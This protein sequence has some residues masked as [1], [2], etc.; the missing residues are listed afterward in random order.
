MKPSARPN[1]LQA[2]SHIK[3]TNPLVTARPQAMGHLP[4]SQT[5]QTQNKT[6]RPLWE[7]ACKRLGIHQN[8]PPH[9]TPKPKTKPTTPVGACLQAIRHSAR[10]YRLRASSHIVQKRYSSMAQTQPQKQKKGAIN[11]PFFECFFQS[12]GNDYN[13]SALPDR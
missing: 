6:H 12:I 8:Y 11:A 4:N 7:L 3:S 2:S 13:F 1:R 5:P 10:S 9:K